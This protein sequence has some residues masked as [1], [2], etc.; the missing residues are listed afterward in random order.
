MGLSS[1]AKSQREAFKKLLTRDLLQD[2]MMENGHFFHSTNERGR[3]NG[4][5]CAFRGRSLYEMGDRVDFIECK[6]RIF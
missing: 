3:W 2:K 6:F 1:E 4:A 5:V